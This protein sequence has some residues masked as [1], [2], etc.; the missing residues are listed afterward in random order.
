MYF[1]IYLFLVTT[2]HYRKYGIIILIIVFMIALQ[3]Q[4]IFYI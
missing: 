4:L 2:F 3:Q 1:I